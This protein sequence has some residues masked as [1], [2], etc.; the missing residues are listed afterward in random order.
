MINLILLLILL[1][2]SCGYKTQQ[3]NLTFPT[4]KTYTSPSAYHGKPVS[5]LYT[6]PYNGID[7]YFDNDQYYVPPR[8]YGINQDNYYP[9]YK[10][11]RLKN[12]YYRRYKKYRLHH[13]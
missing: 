1:I 12:N 9:R 10:N 8:N 4:I 13:R 3:Q 2:S 11:Y 7:R 6:N 5:R